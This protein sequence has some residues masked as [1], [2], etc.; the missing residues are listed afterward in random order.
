MMYNEWRDDCLDEIEK[1]KHP[2]R[3]EYRAIIINAYRD[4]V[5]PLLKSIDVDEF[6]KNHFTNNDVIDNTRQWIRNEVKGISTSQIDVAIA[7]L[8]KLFKGKNVI[9]LDKQSNRLKIDMSVFFFRFLQVEKEFKHAS[10]YFPDL[11]YIYR[12]FNLLVVDK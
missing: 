12:H 1:M 3:Q 6:S 11:A 4:T 7:L 8:D 10:K 9:L 5:N 2:K